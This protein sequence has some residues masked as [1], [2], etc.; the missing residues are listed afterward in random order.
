MS[1]FLY[2]RELKIELGEDDKVVCVTEDMFHH[3]NIP[4]DSSDTYPP[5]EPDDLLHFSLNTGDATAQINVTSLI[6]DDI[7]GLDF[8]KLVSVR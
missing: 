7:F 2:A 1:Y 6:A 4:S 5:R 3:D 8:D